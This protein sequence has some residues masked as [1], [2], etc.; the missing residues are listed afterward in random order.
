MPHRVVL[1]IDGG[2]IRG[3]IPALVVAHLEAMTK[4]PAC[5][6]FDLIVG[7]STGGIL[8]LGLAL[9]NRAPSITR[10]DASALASARPATDDPC[11]F[12]AAELADLYIE[13]GRSIFT[14]SLW[15]GIRSA[16]GSLDETYDHRPLEALLSDYFGDRCLGD[17]VTPCMVTAYDIAHRETLFMKSWQSRDVALLCRAAARATSAAPAYFEPA[18][19]EA[20]T[21]QRA[22]IDGGVFINSPAVSA[23]AE[24]LRLFPDHELTVVSLGTGELTR[25]IAISDARNWG[26][27]GWVLPLL[28]CM[29]DGHSKAVDQQ[30]RAFL[31]DRYFRLQA[32]LDIASDDLDD[33]SESNL[34]ALSAVAARLIEDNETTLKKIA[35]RLNSPRYD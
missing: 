17:L 19:L 4:R 27:I 6:L 25:P 10:P 20:S 5:E 2:G 13:H 32:T 18:E 26:K 35:E 21:R 12:R 11:E 16:G 22:L 23:Y 7:T 14:R 15:R 8:A 3:L 33:A 1:S 29:F 30:M 24:A 28:D 34:A 9:G 31:G